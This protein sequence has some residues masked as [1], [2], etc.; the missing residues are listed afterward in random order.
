MPRFKVVVAY[1]GTDFNGWQRQPEGT[2]I[3]QLLE[4]ALR[5]LD[6]RDVPVVGAGR[7]DAG[8]H[9]LA[10]VAAFSL[11]RAIAPDALVRAVN[12]RLPDSVRVV[13]AAP[14]DAGFHPRFN[15]RSKTYLYRIWNADV[16]SPFERRYTW[17][18][19][20]RLDV[21]AMNEA[22]Q[23]LEGPHD[24]AAF[25][26]TGSDAATTTRTILAS[27]LRAADC[28]LGIERGL[29]RS[30]GD[31]SA[32]GNPQSA[33]LEYR[34]TGDGFLR[35]M[36][37]NIVGSLVDIGRGRCSPAWLADVLASRDR[38]RAGRTAPAQGLF[39]VG[40]QYE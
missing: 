39:L 23:L 36:V 10:Q 35:Y 1:D 8:V 19:I 31:R 14:A 9:A 7:T 40:V 20:D 30:F 18:V 26:G 15:A 28:G 5:D 4:D 32:I 12:V 37:R 13:D 33:I 21:G 25:Q 22:A 2:S 17:H 27:S 34:V 11:E 24:F 16:P 38:T 29:P 3:Q 6:G